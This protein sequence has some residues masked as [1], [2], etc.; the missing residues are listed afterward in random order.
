MEPNEETYCSTQA[1]FVLV[2][3][4]G[5][6]SWVNVLAKESITNYVDVALKL[7]C[8][9]RKTQMTWEFPLDFLNLLWDFFSG[10]T[11]Q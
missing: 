3:K 8:I 10:A 11:K 5:R 9:D 2:G 1:Q 4:V 6:E 7:Y